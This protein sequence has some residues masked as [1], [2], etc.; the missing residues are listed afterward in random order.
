[1]DHPVLHISWNDAVAFCK[2]AGKRLPTEAER[3]MLVKVALIT[4]DLDL[5][6]FYMCYSTEL[7]G[8]LHIFPL[9]LIF[10]PDAFYKY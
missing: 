8:S 10:I 4:G 3:N 7:S 9:Y 2:W 5:Y 6:F 1:M